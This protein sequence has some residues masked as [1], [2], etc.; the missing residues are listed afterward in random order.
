MLIA[1]AEMLN[2]LRSIEV[3]SSSSCHVG[4]SAACPIFQ[5]AHCSNGCIRANFLSKQWFLAVILLACG[6]VA[7][8]QTTRAPIGVDY[9]VLSKRPDAVT[10]LSSA[11]FVTPRNFSCAALESRRGPR[12]CDDTCVRNVL[13]VAGEEREDTLVLFYGGRWCTWSS[14]LRPVWAQLAS[15]FPNLCLIAIDAYKHSSMNPVVGVHAFPTVLR[16][17]AGHVRQKYTGERT[18]EDMTAWIVNVTNTAPEQGAQFEEVQSRYMQCDWVNELN[19]HSHPTDWLLIA[20]SLVSVLALF[21]QCGIF[22]IGKERTP[23]T[24]I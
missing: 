16:F 9:L 13:R 2:I 18:I 22:A 7:C 4:F 1:V 3:S 6:T 8:A 19:D 21:H 10:L 23:T 12:V 17:Q 20:S 15:R 5:M 14:A 24:G 11:A